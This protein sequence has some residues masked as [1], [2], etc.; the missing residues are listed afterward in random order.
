MAETHPIVGTW[1]LNLAKSGFMNEPTPFSYKSCTRTITHGPDG[2]TTKVKA[3]LA[4][5]SPFAEEMTF[6]EDG[7]YYPHLGNDMID[8]M[9][10]AQVDANTWKL[11]AK[12]GDKVVGIGTRTISPDGKILRMTFVYPD[13]NGILR[14]H[15]TAYDK[16]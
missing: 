6:K 16:Q 15:V 12:K 1:V 5:G 3:I 4:D 2:I 13:V 14:G 8:T 11:T 9:A 10:V 7:K